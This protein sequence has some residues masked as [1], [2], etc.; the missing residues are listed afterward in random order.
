MSSG[1]NRFRTKYNIISYCAH[2]DRQTTRTNATPT[3]TP[4]DSSG[5]Q[6]R[7]GGGIV[8]E[9]GGDLLLCLS[10]AGETVRPRL[11]EGEPELRVAVL[12]VGLKVLADG[13]RLFD[14]VPEVLRDKWAQ[15]P[16]PNKKVITF[17]SDA[18]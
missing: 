3:P 14:E 7:C 5:D 12:P 10:I 9:R 11:D 1:I 4:P 2:T 17:A 16:S 18:K 8:L 15:V 6:R 13:D